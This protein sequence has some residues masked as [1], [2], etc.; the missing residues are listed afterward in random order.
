MACG[1]VCYLDNLIGLVAVNDIKGINIALI[2][3]YILFWNSH[4]SISYVKL[5][6]STASKIIFIDYLLSSQKIFNF[7]YIPSKNFLLT[8]KQRR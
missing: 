4:Y 1:V 6:L 5:T 8:S 2:E 3:L 7:E